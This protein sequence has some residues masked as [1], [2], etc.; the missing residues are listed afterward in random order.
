MTRQQDRSDAQLRGELSGSGRDMVRVTVY[1]A[2]V[3]A[4]PPSELADAVHPVY[5]RSGE[6]EDWHLGSAHVGPLPDDAAFRFFRAWRARFAQDRFLG[7]RALIRAFLVWADGRF[8]TSA[9]G[10]L[11]VAHGRVDFH[12]ALK[13]K[14]QIEI[15]ERVL[16][17]SEEEGLGLYARRPHSSAMRVLFPT[18]PATLLLGVRE[19]TL[20][21]GTNGLNLRQLSPGPGLAPLTGWRSEDAKLTVSTT[22]GDVDLTD[23][24]AAILLS[25]AGRHAPAIEVHGAPLHTLLASLLVFVRDVATL[26]GQSGVD[27]HIRSG[28]T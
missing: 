15:A 16:N 1:T 18:E 17:A 6:L 2:A 4:H 24:D 22:N 7:E 9:L 13:M 25:I 10:A 26:A 23:T 14:T 3:P 28:W 21:V 19:T 5:D 12:A 27:L 8:D 11:N 20:T